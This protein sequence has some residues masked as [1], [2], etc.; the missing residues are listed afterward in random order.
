MKR[1][2]FSLISI[3]VLIAVFAVGA[4]IGMFAQG[5]KYSPQIDKAEKA[6]KVLSSNVVPSAVV[7]GQ[8]SD[9]NGRVVTVSFNGDTAVITLKDNA[10]V[11]SFSGFAAGDNTPKA[12]NLTQ[13]QKGQT[14]SI[15]AKILSDGS[16]RGESLIILPAR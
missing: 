8:I 6:L 9:I 11:S 7:Y 5:Q 12:I 1:A 14:V 10:A 15:S 2:T 13:V 3:I 16:L 4:G